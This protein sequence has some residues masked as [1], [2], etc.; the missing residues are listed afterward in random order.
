MGGFT[1]SYYGCDQD[2]GVLNFDSLENEGLGICGETGGTEERKGQDE[3]G[4]LEERGLVVLE[5][6]EGLGN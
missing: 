6:G 1:A 3:E 5:L 4:K 2:T